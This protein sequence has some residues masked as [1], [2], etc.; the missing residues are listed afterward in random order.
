MTFVITQT[1]THTVHFV[2][3]CVGLPLE[4]WLIYLSLIPS[5][6]TQKSVWKG[7]GR[8]TIW[9]KGGWY[10][11]KN[12]IFQTQKDWFTHE[13]P[14]T[15]QSLQRLGSLVTACTRL[16]SLKPDKILSLRPSS[17]PHGTAPLEHGTAH[18]WSLL[19]P[20]LGVCVLPIS[21]S[22]WNGYMG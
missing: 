1:H 3:F 6:K 12:G 10:L 4:K 22:W 9:D 2:L 7:W 18:T 11:Q 8:K 15:G 21:T 17:P 20:L 19:N 13:L 16:P 14:E 5:L